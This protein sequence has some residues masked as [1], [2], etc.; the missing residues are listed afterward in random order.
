M[1]LYFRR[2]RY[3]GVY[4]VLFYQAGLR[5]TPNTTMGRCNADDKNQAGYFF[6]LFST[7]VFHSSPFSAL[8]SMPMMPSSDAL[9]SSPASSASSFATAGRE[10]GLPSRPGMK[11]NTKI[12]E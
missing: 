9:S 11:K 7:F 3:F 5:K 4:F 2:A 1:L 12:S 6:F 8:S 10:F